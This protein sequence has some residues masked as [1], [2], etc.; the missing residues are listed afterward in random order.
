LLKLV[1]T[2]TTDNQLSLLNYIIS[3]LEKNSPKVLRF[4]EDF[5]NCEPASR[6]SFQTVSADM[7]TLQK[8]F[9]T[10]EKFL[11]SFTD[12]D[13]FFE[14]MTTFLAKT[15]EEVELMNQSFTQMEGVYKSAVESYGEDPKT[16]QPED[17]F[18]T[19]L[20][21]VVLMQDT[22][23]QNKLAIENAE[24]LKRREEAK[25]KRQN[26]MDAKKKVGVPEGP[27]GHDNVV[28]E[29]FG[30]LKGGNLFKNRRL[31]TQQQTQQVN[32]NNPNPNPNPL[33]LSKSVKPP[34][35]PTKAPSSAAVKK[36]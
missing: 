24:K 3:V 13:R 15:R 1:D 34:P 11:Q 17:F 16:M 26:E 21:F 29:L 4:Y 7:N 12:K 18:G 19:V 27:E 32:N 10:T 36:S 25:V 14:T 20:K 28:D 35:P 6:V 31:T 2:K 9:Q 33:M 8:D 5:P 23:R 22:Q 30:A